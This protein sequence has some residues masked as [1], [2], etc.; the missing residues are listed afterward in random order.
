MK[1]IKKIAAALAMILIFYSGAGAADYDYI[2]K[3]V[4]REM[5]IQVRENISRPVIIR[6]PVRRCIGAA[7]RQIV[8]QTAK[9]QDRE[10][11]ERLDFYSKNTNSFY[12]SRANIIFLSPEANDG[13][14]AHELC[15][16]FQWQYR[17]QKNSFE[18]EMEALKI[19][20]EYCRE[21]ELPVPDR[22]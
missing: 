16:Y 15:H 10:S 22:L 1:M 2:V 6:C 11:L 3:W 14:I 18:A 9:I 20:R 17:G 8:M 4:A 13:L 21:H 5:G 12:F 19:E 7:F